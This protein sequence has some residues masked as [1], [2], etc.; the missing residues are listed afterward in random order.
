MRLR[1]EIDLD[2]ALRLA[3]RLEDE[4]TTRRLELRK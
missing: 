3:I 1:P 4:E 2:R